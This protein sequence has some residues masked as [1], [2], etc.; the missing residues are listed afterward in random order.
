VRKCDTGRG[1]LG[2]GRVPMQAP[3]GVARRG[4]PRWLRRAQF[5]IT[6]LPITPREPMWA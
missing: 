3:A 1:F 5:T 6:S 4:L 2:Q